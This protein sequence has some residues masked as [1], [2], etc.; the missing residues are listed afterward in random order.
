LLC[1]FMNAYLLG[2]VHSPPPEDTC[3][4]AAASARR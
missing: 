3:V 4:A 2:H 1:Q